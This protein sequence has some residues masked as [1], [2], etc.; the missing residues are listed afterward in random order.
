VFWDGHV[1]DYEI[2][3]HEDWDDPYWEDTDE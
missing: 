3:T 2:Y 1:G